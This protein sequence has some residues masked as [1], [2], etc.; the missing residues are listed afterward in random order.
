MSPSNLFSIR[1]KV[2]GNGAEKASRREEE[3]NE[4]AMNKMAQ[5]LQVFFTDLSIA[6][7][8]QLF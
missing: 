7:I 8:Q 2:R 4:K 5:L 1:R 6:F 3:Q